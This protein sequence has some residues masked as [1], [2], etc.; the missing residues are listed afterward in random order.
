[1][2]PIDDPCVTRRISQNDRDI[3]GFIIGAGNLQQFLPESN[4][5][6]WK[7]AD[8]EDVHLGAEKLG[9][10]KGSLAL[11]NALMRSILADQA[12]GHVV[13][14][15]LATFGSLSSGVAEIGGGAL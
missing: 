8:F 11:G 5:D 14:R 12:I 4:P 1:M 13:G 10:T 2:P 9:A 3:L 15:G 6:E 7:Q